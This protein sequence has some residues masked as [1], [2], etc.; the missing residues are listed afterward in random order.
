MQRSPAIGGEKGEGPTISRPV[1]VS[2]FKLLLHLAFLSRSHSRSVEKP[3]GPSTGGSSFRGD[4]AAVVVATEVV[5]V[6]VGLMRES[7]LGSFMGD[8]S[9]DTIEGP[10]R[11]AAYL[12]VIVISDFAAV[13]VVLRVVR[14]TFWDFNPG[15]TRMKRGAGSFSWTLR[16]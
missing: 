14:A 10:R 5:V 3:H 9:G 1:T 11:F 7:G 4:K 12:V 2:L 15:A 6:T 16:L 13:A 8:A